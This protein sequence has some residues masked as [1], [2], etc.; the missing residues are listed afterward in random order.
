MGYTQLSATYTYVGDTA[1]TVDGMQNAFV[2]S[3]MA[4]VRLSHDGIWLYE[5]GKKTRLGTQ[6]VLNPRGP[7]G[8]NWYGA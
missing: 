2:L 6:V 1:L 3:S 8:F 4:M 5:D 7:T